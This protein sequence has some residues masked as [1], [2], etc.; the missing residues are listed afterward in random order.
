VRA[1]SG[2]PAESEKSM[3]RIGR[4]AAAV[5]AVV[6]GAVSAHANDGPEQLAKQLQD[7]SRALASLYDRLATYEGTQALVKALA[8][9]KADDFA[10]VY[11]GLE[12]PVQNR[13][14]WVRD[15][16]DVIVSEPRRSDECVLREDL[17]PAERLLYLMIA[18]KY[19]QILH[20]VPPRV[21]SPFVL[22]PALI[23]PGPF[24]DELKAN[25]LVECKLVL[26]QGGS[27]PKL[28]HSAPYRFC[29]QEQP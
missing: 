19:A 13:C 22:V 5:A 7:R 20:P 14:A 3:R 17:T 29:L 10:E 4:I 23:P 25:G 11:A 18:M 12:L 21:P 15:A 16:V 9:G 24:L 2:V 28:L 27:S 8:S 26:A 1:D 6:L